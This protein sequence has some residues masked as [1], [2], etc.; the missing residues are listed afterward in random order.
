LLAVQCRILACAAAPGCC[1]PVSPSKRIH[2][3]QAR[4]AAEVPIHRPEFFDALS[5]TNRRNP[6]VVDEW[7]DNMALP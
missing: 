4:K 7:S 2:H 1:Q 6:G 5:Q 3:A